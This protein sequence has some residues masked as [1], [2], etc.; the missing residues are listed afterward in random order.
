MMMLKVVRCRHVPQNRVGEGRQYRKHREKWSKNIR[1]V[2]LSLYPS[3]NL[4][5]GQNS[6]RLKIETKKAKQASIYIS[7]WVVAHSTDEQSIRFRSEE[8]F[9]YL[10]SDC[11][12]LRILVLIFWSMLQRRNFRL[13]TSG[14]QEPSE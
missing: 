3:N 14:I 7:W 9:N 10:E 12:H 5:K 11:L 2:Y 4:E 8:Y 1:W 6:W 13:I